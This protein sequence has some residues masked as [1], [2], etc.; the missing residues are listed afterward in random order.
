MAQTLNVT[1]VPVAP[2]V[3]PDDLAFW[4]R[5]WIDPELDALLYRPLD[6]AG[7]NIYL[8]VD[9]ILHKKVTGIFN[10][11]TLPVPVQCLY[12]GKAEEEFAET[13]PYLVD[14]TLP[15]TGPTSFHRDFFVKHWKH[16]TG[17]VV[18]TSASMEKVRAHFR[19]FTKTVNQAGQ[20]MFFRFWETNTL[21]DYFDFLS[22]NQPSRAKDFFQLRDDSWIDLLVGHANNLERSYAVRPIK[23]ELAPMSYSAGGFSITPA[24]EEALYHGI[25]RSHAK[26]I[27]EA[28]V[29]PMTDRPPSDRENIVHGCIVRSR[30]YGITKLDHIHIL[31]HWDLAQN[32]AFERHA[33][34]LTDVLTSALPEDEKMQQLRKM[35]G[36]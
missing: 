10:L 14:L 25:L 15:E 20:T 6:D 23:N 22:V 2:V 16:G 19:R 13:A 8:I 27:C 7:G 34:A 36:A 31:A 18:R 11:D 5:P 4:E 29:D 32:G 28:I 33:P 3:Q 17:I 1:E 9:A 12:Q 30:N 21:K 26:K 35:S 24:E